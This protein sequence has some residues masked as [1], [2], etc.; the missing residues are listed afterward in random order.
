M[1]NI[2]ILSKDFEE[3][4]SLVVKKRMPDLNLVM[5]TNQPGQIQKG[6]ACE[7]L[8]GDAPLIRQVLDVLPDL[9]WAQT[10]WAGVEPLVDPKVRHDYQLTNARNVFGPLMSE[11]VFGYLLQHQRRIIQRYLTQQKGVWDGSNSDSLQGKKIGLLGVGSI[12]SHL[13]F[14]AKHFG[15]V[16]KGFTFSTN[17]CSDVDEY[18]HEGQLWDFANGLDFLINS[19]PNTKATYHMINADL[20]DH[21]PNKCVL[22]NVGRGSTL[23]EEALIKALNS[24]RLA[25]AVLDVFQQEPLPEEHPLWQTPN[26]LITSHTA[27]H[28]Y[29]QNLMELFRENYD[30]FI[31]DLPLIGLINFEKGY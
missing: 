1:K 19:L 8:F 30:R 28:S 14:T 3:F 5:A 27:A 21:L 22:F 13:A 17:V 26:V 2:I 9:Q 6:I 16:V 7:I 23:D 25:G 11:Y 4:R 20:I 12:G 29:P 24:G 31:K 18:F 15:M 10:T